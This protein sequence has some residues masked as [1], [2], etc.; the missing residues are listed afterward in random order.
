MGWMLMVAP[1]SKAARQAMSNI[2]D[3]PPMGDVHKLPGREDATYQV[4][5]SLSDFIRE[6]L[7]AKQVPPENIQRYLN[8][9]RSLPRYS[10]AFKV[11]WAFIKNRGG[12]S[13]PNPAGHS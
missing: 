4:A 10:K 6:M 12:P 7:Q 13:C 8:S 3:N 11:L 2:K 9:I 1:T 5:P